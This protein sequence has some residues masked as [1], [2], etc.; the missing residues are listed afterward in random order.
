IPDNARYENDAG[1]II[2]SAA[3]TSILNN[4]T[5]NEVKVGHVRESLLQ[6][7]RNLF[8]ANWSFIGFQSTEPL[9]IGSMNSHPDYAAAPRNNHTQDLTRDVT[10]DDTF[11][12]TKTGWHGDH[13]VKAG[14]A[15]SRNAALPQG[16]AAN[17]PGLYTSPTNAPFNPADPKTY[18]YRFGV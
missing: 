18:P 9:D 11:T 2:Y 4:Q 7:P 8:D 13:T 15:W 14:V 3:W 5:T 10:I 12:R 1:D 6:G 16:T 17:F